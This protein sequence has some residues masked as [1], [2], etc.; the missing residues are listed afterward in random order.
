MCCCFLI[1][2][3][4]RTR[5]RTKTTTNNSK[6]FT[7]S[8][9]FYIARSVGGFVSNFSFTWTDDTTISRAMLQYRMDGNV[10]IFAL[11]H[12]HH[13]GICV[14]I[15]IS[16]W[17]CTTTNAEAN[18]H[19]YQ[20]LTTTLADTVDDNLAIDGTKTLCKLSEWPC[21][22]GTCISLSKFCDNT[23]DCL[24]FSDEPAECS[25]KYWRQRAA[26]NHKIQLSLCNLQLQIVTIHNM[27]STIQ[28]IYAHAYT[29]QTIN[30][31]HFRFHDH[32]V[33]NRTVYG[34]AGKTYELE[35]HKPK[36]L[37]FLCHIN[38]TAA[39]GQYGDIVQVRHTYATT[40]NVQIQIS[41]CIYNKNGPRLCRTEY[42]SKIEKKKKTKYK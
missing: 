32:L 12:A 8:L 27:H 29:M 19:S 17:T 5:F 26:I 4:Y 6:L 2:Y 13:I 23:F 40:T 18:S 15:L 37:P 16:T 38:F 11:S 41:I 34:D 33:C 22:N 9:W 42:R 20:Q 28:Y 3:I 1:N 36:S 31:N 25:G 14:I 21:H 39:G 10:F 35:I 24:D 7:N 30:I